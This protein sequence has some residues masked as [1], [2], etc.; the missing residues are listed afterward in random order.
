VA[1]AR[2]LGRSTDWLLRFGVHTLKFLDDLP[3]A[4]PITPLGVD[5]RPYA[6]GP[7]TETIEWD[8]A[9]HAVLVRMADAYGITRTEVQ[10]LGA[11]LMVFL[12]GLDG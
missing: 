9:D 6:Y 1:T 3:G 2:A 5:D 10:K 4:T 8:Q 12:A 11:T 7:I